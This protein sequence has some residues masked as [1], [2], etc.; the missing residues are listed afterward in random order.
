MQRSLT[1]ALVTSLLL[2]PAA[3]RTEHVAGGGSP[4]SKP[5]ATKDAPSEAAQSSSGAGGSP[6]ATGAD[7]SYVPPAPASF[8]AGPWALLSEA[9]AKGSGCHVYTTVGAGPFSPLAWT[10]CGEGCEF[11][12]VTAGK[13]PWVATS[14]ASNRRGTAY[15]FWAHPLGDM[16]GHDFLANLVRLSDGVTVAAMGV[17]FGG[18]TC[19]NSYFPNTALVAWHLA[20]PT[21]AERQSF[22]LV[23]DPTHGWTWTPAVLA[24]TVPANRVAFDMGA[25]VVGLGMGAVYALSPPSSTWEP[26]ESP[27]TSLFGA[28]GDDVAVWVESNS[29]RLRAWKADGAGVRTLTEALPGKTCVVAVGSQAVLTVASDACLGATNG[30]RL[31]RLPLGEPSSAPE[32][33]AQIPGAIFLAA[34]D[35]LRSYGDY[36]ALLAW[37]VDKS[38][39]KQGPP[40]F[41]VVRLSTGKALRIDSTAPLVAQDTTWTLDDKYLYWGERNDSELEHG[42][43]SRMVRFPLAKLESL[44]KP[45]S[46]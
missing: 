16:P 42:H 45:I 5:G 8:G 33:V 22:G 17:K 1:L 29:T 39:A 24:S 32:L 21:G 10:S 43:V 25:H 9:E 37:G 2:M 34:P 23:A 11:A 4:G 14:A 30:I 41:V 36:A 13:G 46:G 26:V 35:A 28:G 7:A 38:G 15:A 27:S 31:S 40:Y 19:A 18:A 6:D 20:G 44:G 3:C 12:D